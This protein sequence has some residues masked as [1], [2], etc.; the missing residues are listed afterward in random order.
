MYDAFADYQLPKLLR[1][2]LNSLCLQI[3]VLQVGCIGK[4]LSAALQPPEPPAVQNAVEFLKM[5]GALDENEN[6]TDLGRY[7]SM[8]PVGPKLGKMLIMGAV[9][10]YIDHVLTVV[11]E[12]SVRDPFLLP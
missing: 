4:F 1:T 7:L 12:L 9:F 10:R 6:L 11:A 5:V 3:K 8:L 2:P